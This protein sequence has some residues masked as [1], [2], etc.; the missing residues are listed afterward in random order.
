MLSFYFLVKAKLAKK[1]S[2]PVFREEVL[3]SICKKSFHGKFNLNKHLKNI[4]KKN[5]ASKLEQME[6]EMETAKPIDVI[7]EIPTENNEQI[8]ECLNVAL[9]ETSVDISQSTIFTQQN[10]PIQIENKPIE[11]NT[12]IISPPHTKTSSSSSKRRNPSKESKSKRKCQRILK[13]LDI[14]LNEASSNQV[15]SQIEKIRSLPRIPKL[16]EVVK[17][18]TVVKKTFG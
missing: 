6:K 4:H 7:C 8:E 10:E 13:E 14:K 5:P 15:Q 18:S 11:I 12:N 1:H 17:T 9:V 3:C 2:N 16:R